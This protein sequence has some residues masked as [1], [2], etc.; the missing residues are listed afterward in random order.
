MFEYKSINNEKRG[1]ISSLIIGYSIGAFALGDTFAGIL[2]M[3]CLGMIW[4]PDIKNYLPSYM[5]DDEFVDAEDYLDDTPINVRDSALAL[6][7]LKA[8]PV[9]LPSAPAIPRN[10]RQRD[11]LLIFMNKH[12][13]G[14][15]Y[16][17]AEKVLQMYG[18]KL[19]IVN[20]NLITSQLKNNEIP[21][22]IRDNWW[23]SEP[24]SN[25]VIDSVD[26]NSELV[27]V[28]EHV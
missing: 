13:Q 8:T 11:G 5:N 28:F 20:K 2:S 15:S 1:I 10:I 14:C 4:Y 27:C 23:Q 16:N 21:V 25:T 24:T 6:A 26:V 18:F 17:S 7:A 9:D 22:I 12:L 3:G 19:V